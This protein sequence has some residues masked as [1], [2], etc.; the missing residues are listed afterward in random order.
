MLEHM[1]PTLDNQKV[2]IE[3]LMEKLDIMQEDSH[4]QYMEL[5]ANCTTLLERAR[6]EPNSNSNEHWYQDLLKKNEKLQEEVEK[7][8]LVKRNT[9]ADLQNL[10]RKYRILNSKS[11]TLEKENN[12][13]RNENE[14]LERELNDMS[15]RTNQQQ[16][17]EPQHNDLKGKKRSNETNQSLLKKVR[18]R[19]KRISELENEIRRLEELNGISKRSSFL[20]LNL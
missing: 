14:V 12:R 18:Q 8:S 7:L 17:P 4:K 19:N 3:C 5:N 16:E 15:T 10:R 6:N 9:D 20:N 13:L 2:Q 1:M 11:E